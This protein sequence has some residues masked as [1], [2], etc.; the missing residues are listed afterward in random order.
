M[1]SRPY[2]QLPEAEDD[3]DR[4]W[5]QFPNQMVK[6]RAE[7]TRHLTWAYATTVHKS[8]GSEFPPVVI[9]P[10]F[11]DAYVMLYRNLIYT[12]MTRA[13][14]HLQVFIEVQTIWLA[15]HRGDGAERPT[16]LREGLM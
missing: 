8:H 11:Y 16:S 5:V 3:D 15:L 9:F 14:T 10:L 2:A 4:L 7:D 6:F 13:R 12:A 1:P